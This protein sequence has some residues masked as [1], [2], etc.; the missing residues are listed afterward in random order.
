[1]AQ[2]D[3]RYNVAGEFTGAPK[4]QFVI[5]FCGTYVSA[6]DT[7]HDAEQE[8]AR[9]K[10]AVKRRWLNLPGKNQHKRFLYDPDGET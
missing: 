8:I 7:R 4:K 5:R 9:W 1:M 10:K 6:H 2:K 3:R